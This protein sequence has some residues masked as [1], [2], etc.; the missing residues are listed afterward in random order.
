M[1]DLTLKKEKI[2]REIFEFCNLKWDKKI[3]N[4]YKRND[5]Y[6]KTLSGSQVRKKITKYDKE[7]YKSYFFLFKNLKKYYSWIDV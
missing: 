7:K 6:I 4:F 3:L 2:S 1:E 5:L